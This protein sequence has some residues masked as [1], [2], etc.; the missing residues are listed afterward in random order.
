MI[1]RIWSLVC[2]KWNT[3]LAPWAIPD[4]ISVLMDAPV[5]PSFSASITYVFAHR[6]RKKTVPLTILSLGFNYCFCSAGRYLMEVHCL[7]QPNKFLRA[8][9]PTNVGE[10]SCTGSFLTVV[11]ALSVIACLACSQG[12]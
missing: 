2:D 4:Y 1:W 9:E 11:I 6:A 7:E 5:L 8:S 3:G 12:V 10:S